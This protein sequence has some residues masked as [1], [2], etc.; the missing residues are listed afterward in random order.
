MGSFLILKVYTPVQVCYTEPNKKAPLG[1]GLGPDQVI[2]PPA[3]FAVHGSRFAPPG[4]RAAFCL[5]DHKN[6]SD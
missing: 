2:V 5:P 4:Q 1:T 6:V 3:R